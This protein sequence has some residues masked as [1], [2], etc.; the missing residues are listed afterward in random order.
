MIRKENQSCLKDDNGTYVS[1]IAGFTWSIQHL[2]AF[3]LPQS[4]L[5]WCSSHYSYTIIFLEA[6]Y[7]DSFEQHSQEPEI[8]Q[9]LRAVLFEHATCHNSALKHV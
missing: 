2:A 9:K 8:F 1:V 5:A 3:L 6:F 4:Q 7:S